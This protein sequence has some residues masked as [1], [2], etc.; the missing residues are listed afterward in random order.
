MQLIFDAVA[1]EHLNRRVI[2]TDG[3]HRRGNSS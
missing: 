3:I 2:V 1:L